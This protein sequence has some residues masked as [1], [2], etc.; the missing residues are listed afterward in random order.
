TDEYRKFQAL[1][2]NAGSVRKQAFELRT[3]QNVLLDCLI[4]A[5][6]ITIADQRCVL[7]VIQDISDYKQSEN[8]LV[9]AIDAVMQD[10]S[11]FSRSLI[12]KLAQIRRPSSPGH[13]AAELGDLTHRER[14]VFDLMCAGMSDAQLAAA[15]QLSRNTVRN[16]VATVYSKIN[17]HSRSA[18]IIWGRERGVVGSG[19]PQGKSK[20]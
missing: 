14:E 3:A 7:A 4:Y 17:V 12:E 16:H 19:K 18:A 11:W 15:L 13:K 20:R 5:E 8:Q 6:M 9:A 2:S 10:T 1:L